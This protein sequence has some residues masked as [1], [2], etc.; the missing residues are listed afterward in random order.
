MILRV[1][2]N[3][4]REIAYGSFPIF[5]RESLVA[6]IFQCV[7]LLILESEGHL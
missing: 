5:G 2:L 6:L 1:K 3:G 7:D 4:L